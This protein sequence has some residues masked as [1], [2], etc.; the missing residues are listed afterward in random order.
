VSGALDFAGIDASAAMGR[1]SEAVTHYAVG[2]LSPAKYALMACAIELNPSLARSAAFE[3]DIAASLMTEIRPVP[4]SPFLIGETLAKLPYYDTPKRPANDDAHH[5]LESR[6][7]PKPLRD[8]MQGG[9]LRDIKWKSLVP[10]LAVHD[11]LG[12]R[13]RTIG[14]R[15]YLL[16]AKGGM[17]LPHHSHHGQEWTLIL[18]GSYTADDNRYTRGDFHIAD[19]STDHAPHIDEGEDCI[20]LVVTQGHLHMKSW[21]PRLVQKVV[22]I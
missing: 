14:D 20:C 19:E 7:A 18:K 15:M 5:K 22:G 12:D 4:L 6:L 9:G 11:V 8:L 17:R 13:K 2:N 16:R 1:Q 10:G 3:T 21:L